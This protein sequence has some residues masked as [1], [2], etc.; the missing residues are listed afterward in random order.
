MRKRYS[1]NL[2][3]SQWQRIK[4]LFDFQRKRDHDLRRD[5]LNGLLFL[6]RTGCQWRM[7]PGEFAPW[8][9]VY[10]YFR[11]W[12]DDGRFRRL[13]HSVREMIRLKLGRHRSPSAAVIDCQSVKT[14]VFNPARGYDGFKKIKGR[15]RHVLTDTLGLLLSV[16]VHKANLH[17]SL[18]AERV[19]GRIT[20]RFARLKVI[21]ADQGYAGKLVDY[22][23]RVFG[24]ALQV[25][26]REQER[27]GFVVL[28][29][30]WVV[31]RT[32][33]WF[34]HYRRLAK[35]YEFN[36]RSSEAMIEL[37][38]TRLMLNRL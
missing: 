11:R 19:L 29:K 25:I 37:A 35:D 10:Y 17:E 12:R 1:S 28:P 5:I 32:F 30:R 4:H 33:G 26:R 31:E 24:W 14:A 7:L 9:S 15:K 6:V 2:T 23:K 8:Q 3:D 34:E 13:L 36:P 20:G 18:Q 22:V 16:V 21:F 27:K 38:M